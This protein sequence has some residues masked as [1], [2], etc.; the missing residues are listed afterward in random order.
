[1]CLALAAYE[2]RMA[3]LLETANQL[4]VV[5]LPPNDYK[6]K[7]LNAHRHVLFLTR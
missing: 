5:A 2:N 6:P 3:S 1:M 7:R 4:V